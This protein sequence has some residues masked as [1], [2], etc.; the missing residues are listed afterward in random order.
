MSMGEGVGKGIAE[1][2][3]FMDGR[4][5]EASRSDPAYFVRSFRTSG[6]NK[7]FP[8]FSL[9]HFTSYYFYSYTDIV[10]RWWVNPIDTANIEI[11]RNRIPNN[12]AMFGNVWLLSQLVSVGLKLTVPHSPFLSGLCTTTCNLRLY[13]SALIW[14]QILYHRNHGEH[15][16]TMRAE[17]SFLWNSLRMSDCRSSWIVPLGTLALLDRLFLMRVHI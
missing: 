6:V 14:V 5:H 7:I 2:A 10:L 8:L 17:K 12:P 16:E 13:L 1:R 11:R 4:I 3:H 9:A 15:A